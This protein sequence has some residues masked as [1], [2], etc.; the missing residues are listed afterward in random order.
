M[1][2]KTEV[3]TQNVEKTQW[4]PNVETLQHLLKEKQN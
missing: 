3:K 4:V 2:W 1:Y